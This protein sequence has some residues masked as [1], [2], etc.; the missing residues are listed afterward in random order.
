MSGNQPH[1]GFP[2]GDNDRVREGT[3]TLPPNNNYWYPC[4]ELVNQHY[5]TANAYLRFYQTES[6]YVE[7]I[8]IV[9]YKGEYHG[10]SSLKMSEAIAPQKITLRVE[11]L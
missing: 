9:Q 7:A 4:I 6:A 10:G 3:I 2:V 8:I 1:T 11:L 5:A